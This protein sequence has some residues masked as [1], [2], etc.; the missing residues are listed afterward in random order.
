MKRLQHQGLTGVK[1][2]IGV[3]FQKNLARLSR[4]LKRKRESPI[5]FRQTEIIRQLVNN[6]QKIPPISR[7]FPSHETPATLVR[8]CACGGCSG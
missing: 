8:K 1:A 7:G 4:Q 5:R 6:C 2:F 3:Q